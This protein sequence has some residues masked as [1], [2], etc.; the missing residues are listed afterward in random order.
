MSWKFYDSAGNVKTVGEQ[1]P[2]GAAGITVEEEGTPLATLGTTL[3]FVGAGVTASGTGAEKTITI[4]G[5]SGITVED[6]GSALSTAATTLDFVGAGVTATGSGAEKTITI[7]G[8]SGITV[9]DEGSALST[10]ATTLDF[11]GAGVTATGTGAEKTITIPGGGGTGLVAVTQFAQATGSPAG[12]VT[13]AAAA[14]GSLLVLIGQNN[15]A[16]YS[17]ISCTNVT[18]TSRRADNVGG[19][20]NLFIWTGAV[21]GGSSGTT[22]TLTGG[23]GGGSVYVCE[24]P[25]T[26]YSALGA[27]GIY[28][29]N[30]GTNMGSTAALKGVPAGRLVCFIVHGVGTTVL[31]PAIMSCPHS[32][33]TVDT[34]GALAFGFSTGHD[35]TGYNASKGKAYTLVDIVPA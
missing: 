17:S 13:I 2:A 10:A 26:T 23:G 5:G 32:W 15:G 19:V 3:D 22:I 14:S 31:S 11:V 9:E 8:G 6:E 33:C 30:T 29:Q 21:S 34:V 25:S 4:P 18:W 35:I 1:G 12:S 16:D 7:P 27:N 24:L 20:G 28:A